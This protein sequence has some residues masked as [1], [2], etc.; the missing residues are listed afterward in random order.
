MR[1]VDY[2]T[3]SVPRSYDAGWE[4]S[5]LKLQWIGSKQ[6]DPSCDL[7]LELLH[8]RFQTLRLIFVQFPHRMNCVNLQAP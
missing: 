8:N 4:K 1:N 6:R 7:L 3:A 2:D 5:M